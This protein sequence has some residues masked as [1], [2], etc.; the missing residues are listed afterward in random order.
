MK[1]GR[2]GQLNKGNI[3]IDSPW[4]LSIN[5]W[6]IC[7]HNYKDNWSDLNSTDATNRPVR[8]FISSSSKFNLIETKIETKTA[9]NLPLCCRFS[10][11]HNPNGT[12]LG[13]T[14]VW[15]NYEILSRMFC[16]LEYYQ[17]RAGKAVA[18]RGQENAYQLQT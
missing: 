15:K 16:F 2:E 10:S 1:S 12:H 3:A 7:R 9:S 11:L 6:A 5:W 17:R 13:C 18:A 8:Y 14:F 4:L